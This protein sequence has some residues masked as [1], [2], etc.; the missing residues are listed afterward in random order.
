RPAG[1]RHY[2]PS[3]RAVVTVVC[4]GRYGESLCG[5]LVAGAPP[6]TIR[7]RL[8]TQR[9]GTEMIRR[10]AIVLA[11]LV[12][13][14]LFAMGTAV[15]APMDSAPQESSQGNAG[16]GPAGGVL[17]SLVGGVKQTLGQGL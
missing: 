14:G 2:R 6:D 13:A 5:F 8:A 16:L 15:A 4:A 1:R 11:G 9:K 12:T 17:G 7:D 3:T 10:T